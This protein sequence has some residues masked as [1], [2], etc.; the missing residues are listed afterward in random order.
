MKLS[1]RINKARTELREVRKDLIDAQND[2]IDYKREINFVSR[3]LS[4]TSRLEENLIR[5]GQ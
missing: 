1:K 4:G 5:R 2:G 3:V